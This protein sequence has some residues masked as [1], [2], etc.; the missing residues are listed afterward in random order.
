MEPKSGKRL[1]ERKVF[2]Q[3]IS[4][5]VSE[6]E[7]GQ[8]KIVQKKGF[9]IDISSKGTG[10]TTDYALREGDVLKLHLPINEVQTSLPV[11]AEVMWSKPA[12]SHFRAGLL[13]LS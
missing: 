2:N 12:D 5:E 1:S 4:F 10:I 8:F 7:T 11:Y 13:F 9:G 6:T 3:P